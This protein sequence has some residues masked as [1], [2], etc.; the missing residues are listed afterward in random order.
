MA[1]L[2]QRIKIEIYNITEALEE[3][4]NIKDKKNKT[5]I[6]LAGIA[7]YLHNFYSGIENILKQILAEKG[8]KIA[9]T[10]F[11]HK[12]LLN[13]SVEN[14][15]ISLEFKDAL[16]DYLAFRHFFVHSYG[17]MLDERRLLSLT[18]NAE[19]IFHEFKENIKQYLTI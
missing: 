14:K 18:K 15:I 3:I 5:K 10:E 6:E 19:N 7:T 2:Q 9:K 13:I 17:F 1:D 16:S 12:T 4:N 11:W 8:I